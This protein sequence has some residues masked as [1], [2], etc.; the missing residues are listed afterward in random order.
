MLVA[1][2]Q[3]LPPLRAEEIEMAGTPIAL[4]RIRGGK[5]DAGE[6]LSVCF[7]FRDW[8]LCLRG[9]YI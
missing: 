1:A 3:K 8:E 2:P 5:A 9:S 4:A 6:I 7:R